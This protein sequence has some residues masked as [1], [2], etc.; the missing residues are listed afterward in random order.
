[1]AITIKNPLEEV[2]GLLMAAVAPE[3]IREE[4]FYVDVNDIVAGFPAVKLLYM[5]GTLIRSDLQNDE[6][7]I[8]ITFQ[9]ESYATGANKLT[10]QEQA[11]E[12]DAVCH[13]AMQDMGFRRG[14]H[15][16]VPTRDSNV[17]RVVSR[18]SRLYTGEL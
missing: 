8:N 16:M 6:C 14:Y 3:Y 9:V 13:Q 10:A 11:W 4:N 1:M 18:Y 17:R 12:L 5:G 7:G 2:S 15:N